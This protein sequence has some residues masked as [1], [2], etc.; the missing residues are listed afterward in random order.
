MAV[1]FQRYVAPMKKVLRELRCD[2]F[3]GQQPKGSS[4][5]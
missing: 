1:N 2:A 3:S 4:R 5:P